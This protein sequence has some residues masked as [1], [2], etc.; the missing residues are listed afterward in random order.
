MNRLPEIT[1]IDISK[2]ARALTWLRLTDYALVMLCG[3]WAVGMLSELVIN[4][5]S[6]DVVTL[7]FLLIMLLTLCFAAY[8]GWRMSG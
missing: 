8:T 1:E 2:Q 5:P 7:A 6:E 3:F 4:F